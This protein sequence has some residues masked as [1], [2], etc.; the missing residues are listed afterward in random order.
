MAEMTFRSKRL[1][2]FKAELKLVF[3]KTL[4]H[5]FY[6]CFSGLVGLYLYRPM[7]ELDFF[8]RIILGESLT[9]NTKTESNS[10]PTWGNYDG[11][12]KTTQPLGE[13]LLSIMY[14]FG[15]LELVSIGRIAV[16]TYFAWWIYQQLLIQ[17]RSQE[18]G[19]FTQLIITIYALTNVFLFLPFIQERPQTIFL[20]LLVIVG[21]NLAEVFM[22]S[23]VNIKTT[24]WLILLISVL[25]TLHG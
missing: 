15:G 2:S 22:S 21:R 16:W 13:V 5:V 9:S 12:W 25:I 1:N 10:L 8:W 17:K 6:I 20:V 19:L 24:T 4:F 11:D 3:P 14:K 18:I 7:K 23:R